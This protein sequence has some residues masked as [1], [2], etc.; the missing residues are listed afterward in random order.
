MNHTGS[1]P[2]V[3]AHDAGG[4]VV[5]MQLLQLWS[6]IEKVLQQFTAEEVSEA[7]RA[8]IVRWVS[9]FRDELEF[10]RAVRNAV[11]HAQPVSDSEVEA[12]VRFGDDILT[13]LERTGKVMPLSSNSN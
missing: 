1:S 5:R 12:A 4:A 11:A 8:A 10:I 3:S 2:D 7:N 9:A 13:L 6:T